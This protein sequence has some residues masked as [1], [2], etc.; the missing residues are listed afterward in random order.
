MLT[1][2]EKSLL[3][4][5]SFFVIASIFDGKAE[6]LDTDQH[7]GGYPYWTDNIRSA[8]RYY[9]QPDVGCSVQGYMLSE[10]R[11]I[12]LLELRNEIVSAVDATDIES[13]SKKLKKQKLDAEI[14]ELQRQRAE[15]D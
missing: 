6:Y 8:K 10:D 11:R 9:Q 14:A 2:E 1:E 5:E 4:G 7:S 12:F 15:L 3:S 13:F